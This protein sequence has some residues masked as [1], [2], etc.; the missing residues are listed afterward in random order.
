MLVTIFLG[1]THA[2]GS[3]LSLRYGKMGVPKARFADNPK[4]FC[5]PA[6]LQALKIAVPQ[7][8]CAARFQT[9]RVEVLHHKYKNAQLVDGFQFKSAVRTLPPRISHAHLG[10]LAFY[11]SDQFFLCYARFRPQN[12]VFNNTPEGQRGCPWENGYAKRHIR[13][14][15]DK[16]KQELESDFITDLSAL[17]LASKMAQLVRETVEVVRQ[18][19][20]L[21]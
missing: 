18:S 12:C 7:G 6:T 14:L 11:N 9:C 19:L 15:K 2:P 17:E 8:C 1:L 10:R 16:N 5:N 13:T 4:P 21:N 20:E 3:R